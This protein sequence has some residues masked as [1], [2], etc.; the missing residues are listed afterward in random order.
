VTGSTCRASGPFCSKQISAGLQRRIL[1]KDLPLARVA[2]EDAANICNWSQ[3][4][5]GCEG[6]GELLGQPPHIQAYS[7]ITAAAGQMGLA[8]AFIQ[9]EYISH[10]RVSAS[11]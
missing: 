1:N 8:H 11:T 3:G 4:V 5:A 7:S 6:G 10:T 2:T 9:L